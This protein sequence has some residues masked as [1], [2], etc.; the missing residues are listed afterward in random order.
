M[1]EAKLKNSEGRALQILEALRAGQRPDTQGWLNVVDHAPFDQLLAQAHDLRLRKADPHTVGYVIDRN[2]NY[3]N[4]CDV[5]CTF[6]AFYRKPGHAEGYVH[7]HEEIFA[8]VEETIALGGSGILMQGGLHPDLPL[9]Y[10]TDLLRSLKERYDVYLHCFSP[11]EIHYLSLLYDMSVRDVLVTLK[12]A[13]L[14]SIPGGGAEILIDEVRARVTTKCTG[15][16][17]IAVMEEAH[18]LG[19][20]S[21]ATMMFGIGEEPRHRVEHLEMI[22]SLQERTGGFLSFI[23]WTF[24]PDNTA[25]GRKIP[26]R[27]AHEEY[28]RWLALCRLYLDN[29][30]NIQ[31]SWLTHGLE[32]GRRALSGGANDIGSVMIEENV[33]SPA[34]ADH[35]AEEQ[36]L[37]AVI[38]SAGFVPRLRNAGYHDLEPRKSPRS[39]ATIRTQPRSYETV[40]SL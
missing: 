1:A 5:V 4:V 27:I 23:P 29:V 26:A 3:S 9:S 2:V 39:E 40:G 14:D 13:G 24:Q 34:G 20:R 31:V 7:T 21:T 37:R 33:I 38:E 30:Q 35:Q 19:I 8:R 10:Y 12:E 17:W 25:L 15:S 22:R 6:C 36:N 11:P 16:E 18:H 32:T 28:L